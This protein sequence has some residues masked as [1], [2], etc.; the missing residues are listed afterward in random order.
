MWCL[1]QTCMLMSVLY[2]TFMCQS[3]SVFRKCL[4]LDLTGITLGIL[5]VYLSGIYYA[6]FCNKLWH[7]LY[8]SLF[9][10]LCIGALSIP[11]QTDSQFLRGR[12][13]GG[14][15]GVHHVVYIG[16]VL[17]GVIPTIHWV[18]LN[19]GFQSNMVQ[20]FVPNVV[21]VYA[22]MGLAFAIYACAFPERW[23]PGSFD[24]VG[25][26]HQW[27]HVLVLLAMIWWR[28]A[29]IDLMHFRLKHNCPTT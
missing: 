3:E 11:L 18:I 27:W 16:I 20:R 4:S 19:G 8:L 9:F 17:Y 10:V 15:L 2:H 12:F 23:R 26:S 28:H 14:R 1:S 29:G 13:C 22:I 6:Y 21:V 24:L 25:G 5:S 7:D